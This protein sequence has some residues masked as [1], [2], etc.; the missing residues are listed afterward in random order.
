MTLNKLNKMNRKNDLIKKI[1]GKN[2]TV[3]YSSNKKGE[4]KKMAEEYRKSGYLARVKG[5]KS[6]TG[7]YW[8]ILFIRKNN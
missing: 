6:N 5:G 1:D 3:I 4:L 2:F 7:E 8:E